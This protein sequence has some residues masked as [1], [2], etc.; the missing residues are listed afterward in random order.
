MFTP[1]SP[2]EDFAQD[3][4]HREPFARSLADALVSYSEPDSIV[5]GLDGAWGTGKT[6]ILNLVVKAM[7]DRSWASSPIVVRFNPWYFSDHETLLR[8]FFRALSTRLAQPGLAKSYIEAAEKIELFADLLDSVSDDVPMGFLAKMGAAIF[9]S[10]GKTKRRIAA[11]STSLDEL[12]EQISSRLVDGQRRMIVLIDDI[13][14][15]TK[16][17]IRLM[18]R[19]VKAVADF[20][21]VTYV[22]AFDDGRVR[23]ALNRVGGAD[24]LDKIVNVPLSAPTI[25]SI[26]V[27]RLVLNRLNRFAEAHQD[28][29]WDDNPRAMSV[30]DFVIKTFRTIRHLERMV[31]VLNI[32]A[33]ILKTEVDYADLISIMALRATV[34]DA[35]TFVRDNR[36]YL[37]NTPESLIDKERSDKE[38]KAAIESFLTRQQN[39]GALSDLLAVMFP[40]F[41]NLMNRHKGRGSGDEHSWNRERRICSPKSFDAY[42]TF[43]VPEGD[44]SADRIRAILG[45]PNEEAFSASLRSLIDEGND[46]ALAFLERLGDHVDDLSVLQN[47]RSIVKV[48]LNLGDVFPIDMRGFPFK[49][50]GSTLV[51]QLVYQITKRIPNEQERFDILKDAV[52]SAS[53]S[54]HAPATT[55]SVEDQTHRRFEDNNRPRDPSGERELVTDEHLDEL[56]QIMRSKI[57]SWAM[58]GRLAAHPTLPYLLFRWRNWSD[59]ETLERYVLRELDDQNFVRLV[60]LMGRNQ[61]HHRFNEGPTLVD[62]PMLRLANIAQVRARLHDIVSGASREA[63]PEEFLTDAD[64]LATETESNPE[65]KSGFQKRLSAS[66]LIPSFPPPSIGLPQSDMDEE[67]YEV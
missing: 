24:F 47:A 56:E 66:A 22:M 23:E 44:I 59:Q 12:K 46:A 49:L 26:Q 45:S 6:S 20:R 41:D 50:D 52:T 32:N 7:G 48:L 53:E 4:L 43:D 17:E 31:N 38:A 1:G 63:I 14:R 64:A 29:A 55:V 21:Y 65:R 27:Q 18:F 40:R 57:E 62:S 3:E 11:D 37:L 2:I 9:R 19:L 35:Y 10:R 67:I 36:A 54:L 33:T 30:V 28:Y 61:A 34:P 13:D 58:D 25:T 15:L 39:P 8:Q 51:M 5:V 16:R 42:F 60:V